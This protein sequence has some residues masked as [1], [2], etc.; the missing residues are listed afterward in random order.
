[1]RDI[2]VDAEDRAIAE[3][4]I[5]LARSLHLSSIAEGVETADQLELLRALGCDAI[6]GYYVGRP[7]APAELLR[8]VARHPPGG[9]QQG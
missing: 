5:A 3:A 8:Q 4:V 6:Q 7:M 1:M 2:T 9:E